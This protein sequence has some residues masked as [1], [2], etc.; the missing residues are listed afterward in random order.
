[1][2]TFALLMGCFGLLAAETYQEGG[3][4]TINADG[5]KHIESADGSVVDVKADGSKFIKRADGTT[6]EI[7]ADGS[8]VIK[9]RDGT[10]INTPG[11]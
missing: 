2:R 8:K 6:V 10:V 4:V 7:K 9:E 3:K 11:H 1:M 5:S